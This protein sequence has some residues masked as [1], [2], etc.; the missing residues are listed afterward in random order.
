MIEERRSL[1]RKEIYSGSFVIF[2]GL[3]FLLTSVAPLFQSREAVPFNPLTKDFLKPAIYSLLNLAGGILLFMRKKPG[4]T[5]CT[6]SMFATVLLPLIVIMG[7][8]PIILS[9]AQLLP[10]LFVLLAVFALVFMFDKAVRK[11]QRVNNLDYLL[12]FLGYLAFFGAYF[13][14]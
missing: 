8:F 4:W 12:T 2:V 9:R 10:L 1:T 13:F 14:L 5:I 6:G 7:S 11:N 3:F